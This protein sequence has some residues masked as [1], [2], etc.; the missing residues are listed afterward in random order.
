[1]LGGNEFVFQR[2]GNLDRFFKN[3]RQFLS[4]INLPEG[5]IALLFFLR[6]NNALGLRFQKLRV[7]FH[8]IEY[9]DDHRLFLANKRSQKMNGINLKLPVR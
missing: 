6:F 8:F 2:A 7:H 4:N 9:G 1:M 5:N 3:T